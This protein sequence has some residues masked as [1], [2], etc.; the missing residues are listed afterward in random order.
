MIN[1]SSLLS[2]IQVQLNIFKCKDS[3]FLNSFFLYGNVD[4]K[5]SKVITREEIKYSQYPIQINYQGTQWKAIWERREDT[6]VVLSLTKMT[7]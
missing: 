6:A 3:I 2:W 4:F 5:E 1:E 7:N